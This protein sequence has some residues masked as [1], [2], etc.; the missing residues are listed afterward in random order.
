[1]SFFFS[2]VPRAFDRPTTETY[3]SEFW[4]GGGALVEPRFNFWWP[5]ACPF[6]FQTTLEGTLSVIHRSATGCDSSFRKYV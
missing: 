5:T 6:S 1:M 3:E 4:G 2:L